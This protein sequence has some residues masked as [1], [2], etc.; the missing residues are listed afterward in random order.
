MQYQNGI[1]EVQILECNRLHSQM[2]EFKESLD[3]SRH[4]CELY[5]ADFARYFDQSGYDEFSAETI[6]P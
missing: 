5:P 6:M 2:L 4:S 3:Y 1:W